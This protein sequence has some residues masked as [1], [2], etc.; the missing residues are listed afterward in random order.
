MPWRFSFFKKRSQQ[1]IEKA[2]HL[3]AAL[4]LLDNGFSKLDAP[5]FTSG[6]DEIFS[7]LFIINI[8]NASA[9]L[10]KAGEP[11]LAN[12]TEKMIELRK[13]KDTEEY[14]KNIRNT[15]K[16]LLRRL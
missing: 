15:I 8:Q 1:D 6:F 16:K 14:Y 12:S 9:E 10:K 13:L 2:K 3:E 7:K 4:N 5:S 11:M